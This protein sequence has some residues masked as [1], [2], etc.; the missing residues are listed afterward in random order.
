ML[1]RLLTCSTAAFLIFAWPAQATVIAA[2]DVSELIGTSDAVVI[3]DVASVQQIGSG[4]MTIGDQVIAV[5]QFNVELMVRRV[6]KGSVNGRQITFGFVWP[7]QPLA[8]QRIAKGDSGMFFLRGTSENYSVSDPHYVYLLGTSLCAYP[9]SVMN[10]LDRVATEL[11]CIVDDPGATEAAQLEAIDALKSLRTELATET[12]RLAASN[13][14]GRVRLHAVA[15]LLRRDDTSQLESVEDTLLQPATESV[16]GSVD[17]L[18]ESIFLGVR[19][20]KVIPILQRLLRA[21]DSR[22]RRGAAQALRNTGSTRAIQGLVEALE[23]SQR[24]IR[25]I[26]VIGLGEITHQDEWSPAIDNFTQHEASFLSYWRKWAIEN[27]H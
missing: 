11:R 12:L 26:G 15:A 25:Y 8:Y 24:D 2:L 5:A 19:N 6:V 7:N 17:D 1:I 18:A 14:Q 23:D 3:G 20:P 9:E 10:T 13:T 27:T 21:P 16:R 4:T 22:V